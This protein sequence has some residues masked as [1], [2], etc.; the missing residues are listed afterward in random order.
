MD[1]KQPEAPNWVWT[2]GYII[3]LTFMAGAGAAGLFLLFNKVGMI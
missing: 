1:G 2:V 3:I